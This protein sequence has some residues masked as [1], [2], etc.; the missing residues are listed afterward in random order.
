ME[1]ENVLEEPL[2]VGTDSSVAKAVSAMLG[3]GRHEALVL[4][5]GEPYGILSAADLVKKNI[6]NPEKTGIK[7][8][9]NQISP[10]HLWP[11][12]PRDILNAMLINGYKSMPVESG[13]KTLV[14]S[15][16]GM[17]KF[18]KGELELKGKT[19]N[20]VLKFPFCISP[21]DSI[22]T[23]RA[24]IRDMNVDRLAVVDEKD[25]VYGILD[26]LDLLRSVI[27]RERAQKGEESGEKIR[28][29]DLPVKSIVSKDVVKTGPDTPLAEALG[30]MTGR[31]VTSLVVEK[32]GKL[33]GMV[34]SLDILKLVSKAVEGVHVTVSGIQDEDDF[35]LSV[36]HEEIGH[37]VR[38]LGKIIP[39]SYFVMH[40]RK[41]HKAGRRVKYSVQARLITEKGDF[42]SDDY[43]WDLTKATRGVL[44]K[45]ER[46]VVR[47]EGRMHVYGRGP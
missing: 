22:S 34:T 11:T 37:A 41:Y 25:R 43:A 9:V 27:G 36:V 21:D 35:I 33:A 23:A 28:L 19:V 6:T 15:K 3:H 17:L 16:L 29:G 7:P 40:V 46:E 2:T 45:I 32:D 1:F 30:K 20:D 8:F 12:E 24:L 10:T 5:N 31:N 14:I 39:L 47:K 18:F 13:G 38:K 4:E 26:T 42:F 44:K